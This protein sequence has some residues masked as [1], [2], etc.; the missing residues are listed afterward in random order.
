MHFSLSIKK[1]CGNTGLNHPICEALFLTAHDICAQAAA[2]ATDAEALRAQLRDVRAGKNLGHGGAGTS[3]CS[4]ICVVKM[5]R[6][7]ALSIDDDVSV[8]M[9]SFDAR[10]YGFYDNC[11]ALF[12]M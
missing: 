12:L 8:A 10:M 11:Q 6:S 9:I 7:F 2:C 5:S 3:W 1:T 4:A